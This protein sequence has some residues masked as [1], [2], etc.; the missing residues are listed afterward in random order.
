M[1]GDI[2]PN[3]HTVTITVPTPPGVCPGC[4]RCQHCGQPYPQPVPMV[5]APFYPA[6][7]YPWASP[8]WY[9]SSS[10]TVVS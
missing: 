1:T 4:G 9:Y 8:F 7:P 5:P 2:F 3:T 6:D 10:P